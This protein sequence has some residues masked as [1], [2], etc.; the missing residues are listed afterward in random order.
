MYG[1]EYVSFIS[2]LFFGVLCC[3][4]SL[5]HYFGIGKVFEKVTGIIGLDC[6]IIRFILI[7]IYIIYS[8]NIFTNNGPEKEYDFSTTSE[9][10]TSS[11]NPYSSGESNIKL[12]KDRVLVEWKDNKYES[13]YFEKDNENSLYAKYNYLGKKI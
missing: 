4:L 1:L 2:D 10:S 3:L 12:N 9:S 5:L 8:G 7:L 13:L 11:Q 6:G